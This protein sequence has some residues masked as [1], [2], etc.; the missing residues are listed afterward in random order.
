MAQAFETKGELLVWIQQQCYA[1]QGRLPFG[2]LSPIVF[3]CHLLRLLGWWRSK[4]SPPSWIQPVFH[5]FMVLVSLLF[6]WDSQKS[7]LLPVVAPQVK[8]V[9]EKTCCTN[10]TIHIYPIQ[11]KSCQG[12]KVSLLSRTIK[13]TAKFKLYLESRTFSYLQDEN[14]VLI[15][16]M[17]SPQGIQLL[18]F[19]AQQ[20][21]A[22]TSTLVE[23]TAR[24]SVFPVKTLHK[25]HRNF[26]TA[27]CFSKYL[28]NVTL[29]IILYNIR[30]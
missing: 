21:R 19:L 28:W 24:S 7:W 5:P 29:V 8:A 13:G 14:S 20:T 25:I 4:K 30:F 3:V 17:A 9:T 26:L 27:C 22:Q 15:Y 1:T 11:V 23:W 18:L 2:E 12:V 10:G 6:H 16:L